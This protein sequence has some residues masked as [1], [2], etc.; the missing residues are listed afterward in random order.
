MALLDIIAEN[1]LPEVLKKPLKFGDQ[2]QL[3]A[4]RKM[5]QELKDVEVDKNGKPVKKRFRVTLEPEC[6]IEV[7]VDA[8]TSDAAEKIAAK[9]FDRGWYRIK[10]KNCFISAVEIQK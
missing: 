5:E 4:L 6:L 10:A 7:E 3:S 1:E 9:E 8:I 2:K